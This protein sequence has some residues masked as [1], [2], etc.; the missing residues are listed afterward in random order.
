MAHYAIKIFTLF[1][2]V[3]TLS[4]SEGSTYSIEGNLEGLEEDG[5]LYL[6]GIENDRSQTVLDSTA[7]TG[8]QFKISGEVPEMKLYFLN[9]NRTNMSIPAFLDEGSISVTG[10]LREPNTLKVVGS[11]QNDYYD[12]YKTEVEP[13]Q[14]RMQGIANDLRGAQAKGD[15][16]QLESL[17]DEHK[18]LIAEVR[19]FELNFI[20]THPD[21][22]LSLLILTSRFQQMDVDAE[23]CSEYLE[24]LNPEIKTSEA[25]VKL[26]E[27]IQTALA[28]KVNAS[29]PEFEG[30]TP[31]GSS[32]KLSE[33]LGSKAT[34]I[35]FWAA[36]CK[37]CRAAN[38]HLKELYSQYHEKGLNI[39]GV[40]LDSKKADWLKAIEDDGLPWLQVSYLQQ[41]DGPIATEYNI[42]AIP[43]AFILDANGK[44]VAKDVRGEELE[45]VLANLF[46][47]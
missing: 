20:E 16:A 35:D 29:A 22:Y 32:L 9:V 1:S 38:P 44:I 42:K 6:I 15:Q 34:I 26:S 24:N 46:A 10:N 39:I 37:P 36:W 28:L 2:I 31:D 30:P 13:F 43:S 12:S 5:T 18:E 7:I 40:S 47:N 17:R 27:A 3:L 41:F 21:A 23:A 14:T 8:G 33:N 11:I 25:A 19:T 45:S 4:C